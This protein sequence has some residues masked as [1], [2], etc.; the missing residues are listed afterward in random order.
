MNTDRKK[1]EPPD[2]L[3]TC[4][5]ASAAAGVL[6]L[7]ILS[8]E[9]S[10][11]R[12]LAASAALILSGSAALYRALTKRLRRWCFFAALC[13]FFAGSVLLLANAGLL[14]YSP[15]KIWPLAVLFCGVSLLGA[16][17]YQRKRPGVSTLVPAVL[18]LALGFFLLLFS[19]GVISERFLPFASKWWPAALVLTGTVLVVLFFCRSPFGASPAAED[20]DSDDF[21][22][23]TRQEG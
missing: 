21:Q 13:A 2:I 12:M 20:D 17:F 19:F 1:P 18:L 22:G 3:L 11:A 23:E 8:G 16:G 6:L 14:P 4:G 9:A 15:A 5:L 10:S 7:G